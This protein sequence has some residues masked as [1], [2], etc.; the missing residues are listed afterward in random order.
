M[1]MR[2]CAK[3]MQSCDGPVE[4]EPCAEH[5]NERAR[6]DVRRRVA[7]V[8]DAAG[9]C[10]W[11]GCGDGARLAVMYAAMKMGISAGSVSA[12]RT[13]PTQPPAPP[14]TLCEPAIT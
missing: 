14:C 9:A 13:C 11:N 5:A 6:R 12:W 2:G 10:E 4:E 7:V 3:C 8:H 1:Q